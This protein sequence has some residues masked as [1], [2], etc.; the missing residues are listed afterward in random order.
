MNKT[1][2]IIINGKGYEPCEVVE[3]TD[4]AIGYSVN[5][6]TKDGKFACVTQF[7]GHM[8]VDKG[9][10]EAMA[11]ESYQDEVERMDRLYVRKTD[12]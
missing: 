5:L 11:R 10:N 4:Y 12:D 8:S 7:D 2:E 9:E 6:V 1:I 3:H